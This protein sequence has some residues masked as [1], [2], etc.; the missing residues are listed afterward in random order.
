MNYENDEVSV[1]TSVRR[2]TN[3]YVVLIQFIDTNRSGGDYTGEC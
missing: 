3:H 1:N 2:K